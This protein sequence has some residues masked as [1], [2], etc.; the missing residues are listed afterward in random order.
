MVEQIPSWLSPYLNEKGAKRIEQAVAEAEMKTSGEIVPMLVYRST[1][2]S[3]SPFLGALLGLLLALGIKHG[4]FLVTGAV[5]Q[6]TLW[7][8]GFLLATALGY[9][10]SHWAPIERLM[11]PKKDQMAE[12]E[13]R[14]MLAFYEAGLSKTAGGTGILLFVSFFER[15]AVVLADQGIAQHCPPETFREL[16]QELIRGARDQRLVEGFEVAIHRCQELLQTHFP[17]QA[18]NPNELKN[19][20]RINW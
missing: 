2:S 1:V 10:V 8:V 20:L 19:Y 18:S 5:G 4:I 15:Q 3:N 17:A 16:V 12:T 6:D 9:A 11:I 14:A 7:S 13:R